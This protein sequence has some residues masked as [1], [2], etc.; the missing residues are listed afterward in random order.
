MYQSFA[1]P[2]KLSQ[3]ILKSFISSYPHTSVAI[4]SLSVQ[5]VTSSNSFPQN[6]SSCPWGSS[7]CLNLLPTY[8]LLI[9]INFFCRSCTKVSWSGN[10]F[11][12]IRILKI[13]LKIT[14]LNLRGKAKDWYKRV[15][16]TSTSSHCAA[17]K[18]M[19]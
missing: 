14:R 8:N 3:V 18:N 13:P 17:E 12:R 4:S 15:R 16:S 9:L 7:S 6:N 10:K 19:N 11:D 2:S 5:F 1:L